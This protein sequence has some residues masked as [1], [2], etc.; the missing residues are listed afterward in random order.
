MPIRARGAETV[1]QPA[2]RGVEPRGPR[3][4]GPRSVAVPL[5]WAAL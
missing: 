2:A 3:A 5:R 1:A 4:R